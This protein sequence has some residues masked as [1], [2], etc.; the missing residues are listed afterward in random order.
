MLP[1]GLEI[2]ISL[3]LRGSVHG[4]SVSNV[5]PCSWVGNQE[6]WPESPFCRPLSH[7]TSRELFL[8]FPLNNSIVLSSHAR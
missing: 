5:L 8:G 6:Q 7:S 3:F 2:V 4:A 1:V